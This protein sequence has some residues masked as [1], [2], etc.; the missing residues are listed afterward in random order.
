MA[1]SAKDGRP[2]EAGGG[3]S[4]AVAAVAVG[5]FYAAQGMSNFAPSIFST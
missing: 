1:I 2:L 4:W 3:G 5:N